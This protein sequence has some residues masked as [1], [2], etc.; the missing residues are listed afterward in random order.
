MQPSDSALSFVC[1]SEMNNKPQSSARDPQL[2]SR[3]RLFTWLQAALALIFDSVFLIYVT[4]LEF[5]RMYLC[6]RKVWGWCSYI[7]T[8][9][10]VALCDI[11]VENAALSLSLVGHS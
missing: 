8:S 11:T 6:E 4:S 9:F 5:N 3:K 10:F 1:S 2:A 7:P